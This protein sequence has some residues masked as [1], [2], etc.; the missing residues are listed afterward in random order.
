MTVTNGGVRWTMAMVLLVSV[1]PQGLT[2]RAQGGLRIDERT[3]PR[4]L[5]WVNFLIAGQEE[6]FPDIPAIYA[7]RGETL[8][9]CYGGP[10]GIRTVEFKAGDGVLAD[11]LTFE[12][13]TPGALAE[14]GGDKIAQ[15]A[16]PI[17][18]ETKT[19]PSQGGKP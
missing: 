18:P 11:V 9:I 15:G 5:D 13:P 14:T 3:T 6:T 2:I 1:I 17:H 12:R 8:T 4:A 7:L 19:S 10:N 16:L